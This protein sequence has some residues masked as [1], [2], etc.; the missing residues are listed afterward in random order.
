MPLG[1][2]DSA[3][4]DEVDVATESRDRRSHLVDSESA[5]GVRDRSQFTYAEYGRTRIRGYEQRPSWLREATISGRAEVWCLL[6]QAGIE[7]LS[8]ESHPDQLVP[9]RADIAKV[10]M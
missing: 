4:P 1:D 10:E 7:F 5:G 9:Y 6:C 8:S 3:L 2:A